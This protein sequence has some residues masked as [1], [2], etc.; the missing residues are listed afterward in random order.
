MLPTTV[1]NSQPVDRIKASPLAKKNAEDKGFDI[2]VNGSVKGGRNRKKETLEN[3]V[4]KA[5]PVQS[6]I[7][8]SPV[9]GQ[10]KLTEKK[11]LKCGK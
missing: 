6:G 11:Y 5:A 9:I 10:G 4:P 7:Q 8:L 1:A 3:F 2:A